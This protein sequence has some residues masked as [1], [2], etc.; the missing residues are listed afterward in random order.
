MP[1]SLQT[2]VLDAQKFQ[3]GESS[4]QKSIS[5]IRVVSPTATRFS[6][7]ITRE[8]ASFDGV[9]PRLQFNH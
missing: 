9:P 6:P 7:E 5:K 1:F 4:P 3:F 2:I 8:F